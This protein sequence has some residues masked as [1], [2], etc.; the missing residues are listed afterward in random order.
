MFGIVEKDEMDDLVQVVL[1]VLQI[2][3]EW[4]IDR[5]K[6]ICEQVLGD[7]GRRPVSLPLPLS[8]PLSVLL[9]LYLISHG[10]VFFLIS[11]F[12]QRP[13]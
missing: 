8:L 12:E 13:L 5:L 9:F 10:G 3:D 1:N 7:Q 4:L 2:S 6:D 11:Q